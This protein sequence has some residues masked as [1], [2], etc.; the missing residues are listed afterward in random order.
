MQYEI[1]SNVIQQV[2]TIVEAETEEEA[3][4]KAR[5]RV[6]DLENYQQLQHGNSKDG[7]TFYG[8]PVLEDFEADAVPEDDVDDE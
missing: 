2:M 7:W 8:H 4:E 3:T 1:Y 6:L 5:T